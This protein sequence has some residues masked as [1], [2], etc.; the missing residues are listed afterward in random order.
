MKTIHLPLALAAI[1]IAL[2]VFSF[3]WPNMVPTERIWS[4]QQARRH[5]QAAADLHHLQHQRIHEQDHNRPQHSARSN[6]DA[7]HRGDGDS[8][9]EAKRR[10]QRSNLELKAAQTYR[11]RTAAYFKWA[12]I[13]C[14]LLGVLGYCLLLA[15]AR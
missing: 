7:D 4:Q 8:F 6:S 5:A 9:Q 11:Q 10:Y 3:V 15:T 13:A 12:G 2:I 1:G 14:A